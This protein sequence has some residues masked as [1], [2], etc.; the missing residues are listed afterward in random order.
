M[1]IANVFNVAFT[2][3]CIDSY[4]DVNS[5]KELDE[6]LQN[7]NSCSVASY[8]TFSVVDIEEALSK[9]KLGK[10]AGIDGIVKEHLTHCH[11]AVIVHLKLLFNMIC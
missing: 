7:C 10:A 2:N 3:N 5:V 11:P 6:K 9:L 4:A 8:N 1:D